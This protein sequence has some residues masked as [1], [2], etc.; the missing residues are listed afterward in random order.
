M[1][2]MFIAN[3]GFRNGSHF[4]WERGRL[5][6]SGLDAGEPPALP[7]WCFTRSVNRYGLS[8]ICIFGQ[9]MI[10]SSL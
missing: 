5:A 3:T 9:D 8:T 1:A 10:Y 4:S 6:R 7:G 2:L